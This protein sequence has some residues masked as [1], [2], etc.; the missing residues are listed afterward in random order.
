[1][2]ETMDEKTGVG[3]PYVVVDNVAAEWRG[4]IGR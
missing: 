2:D 4:G 1:V 3:I